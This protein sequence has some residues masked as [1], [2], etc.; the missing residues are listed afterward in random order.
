M[1]KALL[2]TDGFFHPPFSARKVLHTTLA[3]LDG[4]EFQP[5]RSMEKLP[6]N[7]REFLALVIYLHHQK[8]SEAALTAL[9]EFVSNGG[10]LLGVHTATAAYKNYLHYFEILGGRFIGH[11]PVTSFE[12]KPIPESEIFAAVPAFTVKDELYIHELQ[13]G[14]TPHFTAKHNGQEV[15]VVWTYH[16]DKGRVCYA[17]PGHRTETMHNE[18]YQ[19]ILQRGLAWVC[20]E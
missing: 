20:G 18:T 2:V 19:K 4:F 3:E 1:K 17:V 8:I 15:P 10:G 7:L 11:G 16:Y 14:I 6:N 5:V 12:V 9:D 13:L